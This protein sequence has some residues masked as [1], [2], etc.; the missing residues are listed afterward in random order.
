[1]TGLGLASQ[2]VKAETDWPHNV[3]ADYLKN[4]LMRQLCPSVI[5][6][7]QVYS[8]SV[9]FHCVFKVFIKAESKMWRERVS[10]GCNTMVR[11][12]FHWLCI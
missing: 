8:V 5:N 1:M 11:L 9:L 2:G 6:K 10:Y 4:N 3:A 7:Q 12:A